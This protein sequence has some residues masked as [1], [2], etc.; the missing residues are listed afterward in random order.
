[1]FGDC[2]DYMET[3]LVKILSDENH[4]KQKDQVFQIWLALHIFIVMISI[5]LLQKDICNSCVYSFKILFEAS[6][7][8]FSA[9]VFI[10]TKSA[11]IINR[12]F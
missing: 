1:M 8:S 5:D 9:I 10:C 7:Q 3:R 12:A 6:S 11:P 2:Y 4:K